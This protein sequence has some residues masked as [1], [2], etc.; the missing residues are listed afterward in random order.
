MHVRRVLAR[1]VATHFSTRSAWLLDDAGFPKKGT[2][3][4]GVS[5]QY[6]GT[7]GKIGNC[8]IGVSLSYATDEG[9]F[10]LDMQLYLPEAW[11]EDR[12][13]RSNAGVPDTIG[14]ERKWEIGLDMCPWSSESASFLAM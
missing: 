3:S 10:P 1:Y 5:R 13:R 6:S 8:Q 4:V 11:T 14:F 9:S 12:D 7:L 2:K